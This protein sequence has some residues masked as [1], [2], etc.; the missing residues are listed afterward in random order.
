MGLN[1]EP[2]PSPLKRVRTFDKSP[3]VAAT[4][5]PVNPPPLLLT[6]LGDEHLAQERLE[7]QTAPGLAGVSVVAAPLVLSDTSASGSAD[8]PPPHDSKP[9]VPVRYRRKY[10]VETPR[11]MQNRPALSDEFEKEKFIAE[12]RWCAFFT[13]HGPLDAEAQRACGEK[14]C[15]E[16]EYV[17]TEQLQPR[18]WVQCD[19]CQM[20]CRRGH[21]DGLGRV[22]K[23]SRVTCADFYPLCFEA[24]KCDFEYVEDT[25]VPGYDYEEKPV[26]AKKIYKR[27]KFVG[28]ATDK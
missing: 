2:V 20:W 16:Y 18:E 22:N 19:I 13:Q 10:E 17:L 25:V 15:K 23:R 6:V 3:P 26:K 11:E 4:A 7:A 21:F 28:F 1:T 8:P 12:Q 14:Y 5:S 9:W 27:G 24:V